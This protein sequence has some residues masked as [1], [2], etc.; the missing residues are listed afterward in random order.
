MSKKLL[1]SLAPLFAVVAFAVTPAVAQA[2][3]TY[4]NCVVIGLPHSGNCPNPATERFKAFATGTAVKVV[5]RK[6][7]GS[8]DYTL[9]SALGTITCKSLKDKGTVTNVLIGGVLTGTSELTL[10]FDE[11]T[12]GG[13]PVQT[14]GSGSGNIV[15]VVTDQVLT[16]TTVSVKLA[17]AGIVIVFSGPPPTGCPAAGT[18]LG[19]VTGSA[20]G[21]Q[22]AKTNVLKFNKTPGFKF[23]GEPATITG[24]DELETEGGLPVYI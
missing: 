1:L 2:Q 15:G 13:C 11:C 24:E 14:A 21:T 7:P 17:A 6:V 16:A 5:S 3:L 9:T 8:V 23:N 18:A 22:T 10:E 20:T 12:F 19:T 4:G